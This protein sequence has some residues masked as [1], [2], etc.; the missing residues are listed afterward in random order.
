MAEELAHAFP[1]PDGI[2]EAWRYQ[3]DDTGLTLLV[4]GRLQRWDGPS[5]RIR[6]AVSTRD[7][8]G[9][10]TQ[11]DLG[12]AALASGALGLLALEAAARAWA[13]GR[14]DWPRASV[15]TRIACVQVWTPRVSA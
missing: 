12:P 14:G 3:P 15:E 9:E 5:A 1:T 13:G 7:A 11:L 4:D 10:L 2:P 8:A 6:S